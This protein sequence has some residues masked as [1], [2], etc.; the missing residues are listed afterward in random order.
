MPRTVYIL[1][2]VIC[3]LATFGLPGCVWNFMADRGTNSAIEENFGSPDGSHM[4][5]LLMDA[6]R[7]TVL[8]RNTTDKHEICA[9]PPPDVAQAY[10]NALRANIEAD[11]PLGIPGFGGGREFATSALPL[12]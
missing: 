5:A 11:K 9:E 3:G 8:V 1:L 7:R 6:G 2:F 12:F 4:S 10:A